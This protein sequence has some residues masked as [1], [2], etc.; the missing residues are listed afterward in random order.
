MN[1]TSEKIK[2]NLIK[3]TVFL[4]AV[5]PLFFGIKTITSPIFSEKQAASKITVIT[6]TN[7]ILSIPSTEI[8]YES[9]SQNPNIKYVRLNQGTNVPRKKGEFHHLYDGDVEVL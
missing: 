2:E 1:K 4:V 7:P 6:T 8:I 9:M 3:A 5:S